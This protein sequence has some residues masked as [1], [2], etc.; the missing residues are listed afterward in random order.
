[1]KDKLLE[2]YSVVIDDRTRGWKIATSQKEDVSG[3]DK[4]ALQRSAF[5][6]GRR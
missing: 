6:K 5:T 3:K 2:E 1:M 4:Q